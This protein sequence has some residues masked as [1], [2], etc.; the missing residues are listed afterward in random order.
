MLICVLAGF[1]G[2][3][4]L[5]LNALES[6]RT[7]K[8]P[9]GV[10]LFMSA[11]VFAAAIFFLLLLYKFR[12][13]ALRFIERTWGEGKSTDDE[14]AVFM[15]IS[16]PGKLERF[17]LGALIVQGVIL[18]ATGY[19]QYTMLAIDK[20]Y[21]RLSFAHSAAGALTV[22]TVIL[23]LYQLSRRYFSFKLALV[24]TL[25]P[26]IYLLV[27]QTPG[28][29]IVNYILYNL[30]L[31]PSGIYMLARREITKAERPALIAAILA[32][33]AFVVVALT[34]MSPIVDPIHL[35]FSFRHRIFHSW[36]TPTAVLLPA[37][38]YLC[39]W[40]DQSIAAAVRKRQLIIAG[41]LMMA[42]IALGAG[43]H[44][45]KE[46]RLT[47]IRRANQYF[48]KT[49]AAEKH[50]PFRTIST[51]IM[52]DD[53]FCG[54][55]HKIPYRQW[56]RGVHANAARIATFQ[57]VLKSLM[58]QHGDKIALDCAA[59]HD[60]EVVYL[61]KPE[62][63]IDPG[64]LA[65][66]Q[67]V[68]CRVCHY[69]SVAGDKN[70][71]YALE[72]PRSDLLVKSGHTRRMRILATVQEHAGDVSKRITR[73][74]EMCFP[75]HSL[76]SMRNGHEQVP[77][78]NVT[79]FQKSAYSRRMTCHR[80]HMPRIEKDERSYSWMDHSFFGIQQDLPAVA[81]HIDDSLKRE[82]DAL[83]RD[84]G[85]FSK[86]V[87]PMLD[88]VQAAMDETFKSYRF[89]GY[90]YRLKGI[91]QNVMGGPPF[92]MKLKR[93]AIKGSSLNLVFTT[94][95]ESIGHDFPS[96]LFANIVRV[97]FDL[98]L[99]DADG[100]LIHQT[101]YNEDDLTHQLGRIEVY[102]DGRPIIPSDSLKYVRIINKKFIKP[103]KGYDDAW[104][105]PIAA[106]AR[107]PLKASYKLIYKRYND[108]F[109]KWFSDGKKRAMPARILAE[110]TFVIKRP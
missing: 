80:C 53:S 60:P 37:Y 84:N 33:F 66:S 31:L 45:I 79:S 52:S 69:M 55:C 104:T 27:L 106:D 41:L 72:M 25:Y 94:T 43:M 103:G 20:V 65:R 17:L 4:T 71:L 101:K 11:A 7:Y 28:P 32:L 100:K 85:L 8:G 15:Y 39:R 6:M 44:K 12:F 95:N 73:N 50:V 81:I 16:S 62:L 58:N 36:I 59:C 21:W 90:L 70:F 88:T 30:L 77:V 64:H 75:C 108:D 13:E 78:D 40:G 92:S 107:F 56:A 99:T 54:G 49:L 76:R 47:E 18:C 2:P 22:L 96:S 68:S 29:L 109:V 61:N 38:F 48:S 24:I 10:Y 5:L 34:G 14:P 74:G 42:G 89:N 23:Y 105:I 63:L 87:L 57:K 3:Y 51:G 67:G 1:I 9:T 93:A 97:W 26:F 110:K 98:E 46:M 82:M 86:G 35:R 19:G 83:S 91:L 102:A